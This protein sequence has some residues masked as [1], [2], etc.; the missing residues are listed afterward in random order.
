MRR[1]V[2]A[3]WGYRRAMGGGRSAGL[4]RAA[5]GVVLAGVA[6]LA[7]G[8]GTG[9][10]SS[11]SAWQG[12]TDRTLGAAISGLGVARVVVEREARDDLPH[13]YAVVSVT[14]AIETSSKEIG[15]YVVAQ[16]P[17]RLHR[18]NQAVVVALQDSQWMLPVF[19]VSAALL[20]VG[21]A[22]SFYA[23]G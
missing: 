18:A 3:R 9:A 6:G 7:A 4:R 12:S 8:C 20:A 19:F 23:R 21:S 1:M 2:A 14:D 17:D 11:T 16:P 5:A 13:A 10:P 22:M 15:S